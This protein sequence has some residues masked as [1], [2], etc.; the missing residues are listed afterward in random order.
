MTRFV[1]GY[2]LAKHINAD[3]LTVIY[4]YETEDVW[5]DESE[6]KLFIETLG[7]EIPEVF[8]N[9]SW[10]SPTPLDLDKIVGELK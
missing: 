8:S 1:D 3:R 5:D 2:Y 9:Y 7:S 10:V 4:I 6:C